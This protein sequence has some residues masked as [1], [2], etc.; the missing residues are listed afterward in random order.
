MDLLREYVFSKNLDIIG[1]VETFL[2]SSI[3]DAEI[4]S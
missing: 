4:T 1:I 3:S 2:D